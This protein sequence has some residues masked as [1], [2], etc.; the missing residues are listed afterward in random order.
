M[1]KKA[2]DAI[3]FLSSDL[4]NCGIDVIADMDFSFHIF[5]T[6]GW[7]KYLDTP[8]VQIQT[9]AASTYQYTFDDSG[10]LAYDENGVK[11]V[12]KGLAKDDSLFGPGIVVYIEN[13]SEKPITV[14]TRDVSV[15]GF[16]VDAMFSSD[17]MPGKHAVDTI[18]FLSTELEENAIT[19]I[20]N[21][22]LLFHIFNLDSGDLIA[23]TDTVKMAF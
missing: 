3:T 22:E 17:V 19:E 15:N 20:Q 18:T 6:D 11:V 4:E 7:E 5:T 12:I 8:Q 10:D 1:E 23:D 13:S 2:N 9:S 16:M 21:V 14:Q